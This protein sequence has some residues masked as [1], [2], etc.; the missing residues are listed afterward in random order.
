MRS[1]DWKDKNA[2]TYGLHGTP[3]TFT[4][5]ARLAEIE[6]GSYCLLA[7]SGLAAIAMV[8]FA[9][10]KSGDDVLLPDNVYNP[11]RELGAGSARLRH[12]R[13]LLRSADRRRH[14]RA[15]PAEHEADLDRGAGFGVDGSAGPAGHL[16]GGAREGRAGRARQYLVGRPGLRG[17]RS[18]R[19][20]RHAGADQVPVGRLGCADGRRHHA[21]PRP[22]TTVWR[23]R[24]C[25]WA[26]A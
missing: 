19:R 23:W 24:T 8:D 1:G 2:Y 10:L 7:P 6:G 3:T 16:Q 9:L 4:L 15:D 25:A 13:A 11:N 14:R 26:W 18:W 21:R 12:H 5:E 22:A 20:H 17:F